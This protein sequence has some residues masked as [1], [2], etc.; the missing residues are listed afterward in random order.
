MILTQ[1]LDSTVSTQSARTCESDAQAL[2]VA[3]QACK[4]YA[5][6]AKTVVESATE[7]VVARY[8]TKG[9]INT[10]NKIATRYGLIAEECGRAGQGMLGTT[11]DSDRCEAGSQTAYGLAYDN[12]QAQAFYCPLFFSYYDMDDHVLSNKP[13]LKRRDRMTHGAIVLMHAGFAAANLSFETGTRS[14][15]AY[16]YANFAS[17][18]ANPCTATR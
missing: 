14:E 7:D 17:I 10:R 4:D 13:C 11:C 16:S 2:N 18:M 15:D 9:D 3:F 8:F 6:K 1:H 12:N 5:I